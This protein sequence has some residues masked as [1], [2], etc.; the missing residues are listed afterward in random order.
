MCAQSMLCEPAS[1]GVGADGNERVSDA[2][3]A[4]T[5]SERR[6]FTSNTRTGRLTK[7]IAKIWSRCA[8]PTSRTADG[9]VRIPSLQLPE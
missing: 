5:E 7:L 8:S 2:E 4:Q 6:K 9:R 3:W 1:P